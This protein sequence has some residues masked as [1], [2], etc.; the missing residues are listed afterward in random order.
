MTL[1][2]L[3]N[4]S[5][6]NSPKDDAGGFNSQLE[7]KGRDQPPSPP[8]DDVDFDSTEAATPQGKSSVSFLR[9]KV[10]RLACLWILVFALLVVGGVGIFQYNSASASAVGHIQQ[11]ETLIVANNHG[12]KA[13]KEP[14]LLC[15]SP[16]KCGHTITG[17]KKLSFL[18][19]IVCTEGPVN[20]DD[21]AITV[22]GEGAELDCNHFM[23]S[24]ETSGSWKYGICVSNGA[25]AMKCPVQRFGVGL[26]GA[27]IRI[28]DGGEIEDCEVMFN[29]NHGIEV[30]GSQDSTATTKISD[31]FIHD[32]GST[33]IRFKG[34][35]G[36][37]SSIQIEG[38]RTIN[39]G[40]IGM[41]FNVLADATMILRVKDSETSY[42]GL[43]GFVIG[44]GT[45]GHV[46]FELEGFFNSRYNE[47]SGM[48]FYYFSEEEIKVKGVVN[49]YKNKYYG[50]FMGAT[51]NVV[52]DKRGAL[53]S[54]SNGQGGSI[55]KDIYNDGSGTFSG[56]GYTCGTEGNSGTGPSGANLPDCKACPSCPSE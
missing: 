51:V 15:D 43:S 44:G 25:K 56:D 3:F 34:D 2:K 21:C 9:S 48:Y 16:V 7:N 32:N 41:Y 54:C 23:I 47:G 5:N 53:N 26:K 28:E 11:Q 22:S 10:S 52:V 14:S 55:F 39:N 24:Q 45:N 29:D 49:I 38:V 18:Q 8:K 31:T 17:K 35:N 6:A 50:F 13:G 46:D 1:L 20:V 4:A 36:S 30:S 42:N 12:G 19:D 37:D 33:G 27:G 40:G